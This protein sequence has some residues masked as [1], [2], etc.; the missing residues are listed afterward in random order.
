MNI[1][2]WLVVSLILAPF[3]I[4]VMANEAGG[5]TVETVVVQADQDDEKE[6]MRL[7][8]ILD[9]HTEIAT[10]TKLNAD[11]VPGM[12]TVLYGKDLE[13]RGVRTVWEAMGLVP[14]F[15]VSSSGTAKELIIRGAG[16]VFSS[17]KTKILLNNTSMNAVLQANAYPVLEIPV[18]Q[19]ERIEVIRGP[20]SALHGEFAYAGVVNVITRKEGNR[21]F[22]RLGRYDTYGG[23]GLF[24]WSD[25]IKDLHLSLN[26]A[27]METDGADVQAGPDKLYG[28]GMGAISNAPGPTNER[29]NARSGFFTLEYKDFSLGAHYVDEGHGDRFGIANALPFPEDRIV[30]QFKQ[31]GL[32]ARQAIDLLPSLHAVLFLKGGNYQFE[33]NEAFLNPPGYLGIYPDGMIIN[34]NYEERKFHGGVDPTWKGWDRH[35]LLFGLSFEKAEMGDSWQEIN[36]DPVTFA[37]LPS[38]QRFDGAK[39][40]IAEGKDRQISSLILQDEFQFSKSFTLTAGLRYDDY[41]D[42]GE[43]FTPRLAG[44]WR[45]TDRHIL[46]AQF[47][48]AFRPPTFLEMYT[49]NNPVLV[50]N[51]DIKPETVDTYEI[52]YVYRDQRTV[53]RITLFHSDLDDMIVFKDGAYSNSGGARLNGVELELKQQL[54][55]SLK[56]D[57]N[58]SYTD[59]QDLDTGQQIAGV[60]NWLGNI[61][62][63][64][65]PYRDVML[66]LQYRYVGERNRNPADSRGDLDAYHT[67]NVT[68]TL[69]NLGTPGLTLRA[70]VKNLFDEDVHYPAPIDTYPEDYPRPGREW[71]MGVTY[72]Y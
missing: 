33:S 66:N 39:N 46:K 52:G 44:V 62:L 63:L 34:A 37:P 21:V 45:V 41:D 31:M 23:G 49:L 51:P 17:G 29:A 38:M 59:T 15:E 57:A 13:V 10:K 6:M 14:G 7:L 16:S 64:Y 36:Y 48:Q 70:S 60:P 28:M 61:G 43:A 24:S 20:G 27:G 30:T 18:E 40:W 11:Y 22:G 8:A 4:S 2:A 19:V 5:Q 1:K 68:G 69:F 72:D 9:K 26:L 3:A 67:M 42:V 12:V 56:L 50:G 35:N 25:P 47:A 55:S 65:E 71:W 53:G 58:L 54:S 32:E